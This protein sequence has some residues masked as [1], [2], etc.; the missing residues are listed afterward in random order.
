MLYGDC[1]VNQICS[2]CFYD[3][4]FICATCEGCYN[5]D[6]SDGTESAQ[7][8][9]DECLEIYCVECGDPKP[10]KN[11]TK[12]CISC[13]PWWQKNKPA[14]AFCKYCGSQRSD[15]KLCNKCGERVCYLCPSSTC[16]ECEDSDFFRCEDCDPD[17]GVTYCDNCGMSLC[18]DCKCTCAEDEPS[19]ENG[20]RN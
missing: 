15:A 9:C 20:N 4:G 11:G 12:R 5:H 3:L 13:Q 19:E 16:D 6:C 18:Y 14:E 1:E 10:G 2:N 7:F 17:P 8:I